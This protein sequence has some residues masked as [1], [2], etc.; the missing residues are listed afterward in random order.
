MGSPAPQRRQF[1]AAL[2]RIPAGVSG[3]GFL[4]F[5]PGLLFAEYAPVGDEHKVFGAA[6]RGGTQHFGQIVQQRALR[7]A[8]PARSSH[9]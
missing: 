3:M 6:L 7:K 8:F 2:I 5:I 4:L 9:R 1:S